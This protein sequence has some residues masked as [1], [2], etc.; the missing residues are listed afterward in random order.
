MP[1]QIGKRLDLGS[2]LASVEAA[3]PVAAVDV[4]AA[5]LG[6]RLGAEEVTFLISDFNG[7]ALVR[8]SHHRGGGP[9]RTRGADAAETVPLAGTPYE[10]V[11]RT[12]RLQVH[13]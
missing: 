8:L 2:L 9:R 12:Q 11:V 3:A 7:S 10:Q 13:T 1:D 6:D 4:F 5:E